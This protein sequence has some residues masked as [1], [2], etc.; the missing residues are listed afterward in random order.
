[1]SD[2]YGFA[3]PFSADFLPLLFLIAIDKYFMQRY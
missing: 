1:L 3:L 2:L